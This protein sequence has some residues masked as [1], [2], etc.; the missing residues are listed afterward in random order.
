MIL[1]YKDKKILILAPHTDD[2]EFGCGGFI[3]KAIRLG[4]EVAMATFSICEESVPDGYP[5]DTLNKECLNSIKSL[6]INKYYDYRFKVREFNK[7]RQDILD[8][9]IKIKK[10]FNPDI[11]LLP[12][13]NDIH[14]DHKVISEEGIR[15]FKNITILG[16]ILPWNN[17]IIDRRVSVSLL[18]LDVNNKIN[19]ILMY[20]SQKFRGYSNVDFIK[21]SLKN[22]GVITGEK[23]SEFYQLINLKI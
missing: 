15:A 7:V 3:S 20:E 9:I 5:I 11:V 13:T 12:S 16:Y 6:G 18:D 10:E 22:N 4:S 2:G 21:S 17:F 8:N 1:D 23:Y 19:S 14:Q